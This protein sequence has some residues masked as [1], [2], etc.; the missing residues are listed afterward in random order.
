MLLMPECTSCHLEKPDDDMATAWG[1]CRDCMRLTYERALSSYILAMSEEVVETPY[2]WCTAR[3]ALEV[4]MDWLCW[5]IHRT[6]G[7]AEAC[8]EQ[9]LAE[10]RGIFPIR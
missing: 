1:R 6:K 5:H 3:C 10:G 4:P 8:L 2:G 9:T 7:E